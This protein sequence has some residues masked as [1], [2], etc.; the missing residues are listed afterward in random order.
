MGMPGQSTRW[1]TTARALRRAG[2]GVTGPEV[3][4]VEARDWPD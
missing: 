2:F 4:A 1:I 3:D